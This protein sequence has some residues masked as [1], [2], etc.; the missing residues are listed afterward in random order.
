MIL[1]PGF[2]KILYEYNY[3][4]ANFLVWLTQNNG[5][6]VIEYDNKQRWSE[7]NGNIDFYSTK[8]LYTPLYPTIFF[9]L[10]YDYV[11][12]HYEYVAN[13]PDLYFFDK[14]QKH[15]CWEAI[16]S[17]RR[18]QMC[19]L[20]KKNS[21]VERNQMYLNWWFITKKY[22]KQMNIDFIE[23]YREKIDWIWISSINNLPLSFIYKFR[24][25]LNLYIVL[26]FS[27]IPV[28][29]IIKHETL[30]I[31][32][33]NKAVSREFTDKMFDEY[34]FDDQAFDLFDFLFDIKYQLRQDCNSVFLLTQLPD[35]L[36]KSFNENQFIRKSILH[37]NE[38]FLSTQNFS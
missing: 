15:L 28:D 24:K 22:M 12:F 4:D 36:K 3:L 35:Y 32:H 10:F 21:F 37:W 1:F 7:F 30:F 23:K 31:S 38:T 29:F 13:L 20:P 6:H 17:S 14:Y 11:Y 18:F 34:V 5:T 16:S 8:Q 19:S 26:Q 25:Y 33:E 2:L 27:K 9:D